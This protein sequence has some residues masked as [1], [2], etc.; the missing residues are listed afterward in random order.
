MRAKLGRP[1]DRAF[2]N[3]L[4]WFGRDSALIVMM[5]HFLAPPCSGW[6]L[7]DPTTPIA[8][9]PTDWPQWRGPLGS[10]AA[11]AGANPPA[12]W[13]ESENVLWKKSL[14]GLGHSTP[15][16]FRDYVFVTTA[17]AKGEKQ[18]PK[19]SGA[20]G[21]HDNLP[22]T[23]AHSFEVLALARESGQILWQRQLHHAMPHEGAHHTAS[24]ASASPATDGQH[25]Y[26]CFGSHGIG[27]LD[28]E[29]HVVWKRDLGRMHSKHGHGEGAT[30][31]LF[32]DR[33]VV[34][35]DHEGQSFIVAL[36]K[37]TGDAI[38]RA[39][40]NEVTSWSSPLI[41]THEGEQQVIVC[42]TGRVRAYDLDTGKVIWECGG[43]S[44]NIVASPVYGDGI[45]YVGS[46]Y[47]IR[48]MMAI[49]LTGAQGDITGSDQILWQRRIR[50]PYVP[51]PLLYRG[52]VY[53]LAHYQ[54]VLSQVDGASGEEPIGPFR[55]GALGN[56]YAS[57][58]AAA[59]RV[60][61]T[62]LEGVTEVLSAGEVPRTL[63]VNRLDDSFAASAAIAG[64]QLFLRGRKSLYCLEAQRQD[65][66][67]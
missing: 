15:V 64:R 65:A 28:F 22:V 16:V 32:G 20:P 57:P 44:G 49:K 1:I 34:N 19:F 47:E 36:D 38:W 46:S 60:Y 26:V 59:G 30:P 54:N 9:A 3:S 52:Q 48:S 33:L 67:E 55:L 25:V 24:L 10:G 21:A 13:S 7:S 39:E 51:S 5:L 31:A 43:L 45:V 2:K 41:V 62:D 27:C 23:Q 56:T 66:G 29:G 35:W 12:T 42:G 11:H 14:P 58:V 6:Q 61:V 53:F 40:R 4:F 8:V 18:P 50:T 37:L 63:A 17:I